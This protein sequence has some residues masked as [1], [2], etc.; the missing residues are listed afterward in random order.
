[1]PKKLQKNPRSLK[2]HAQKVHF[3]KR[4]AERY[5]LA[6]NSD[7]YRQIIAAI[8]SPAP[9]QIKLNGHEVEARAI[10]RARQSNRV[11]AWD[12][13]IEGISETIP[14][15][16]DNLRKTLVTTHPKLADTVARRSEANQ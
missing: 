14:V 9:V 15:I 7:S 4:L 16:Y 2:A 13:A 12:I 1:M 8:Q 3:K 11:T 6:I 10:F 5:G